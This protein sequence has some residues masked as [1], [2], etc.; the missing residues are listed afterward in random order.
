MLKGKIEFEGK[1]Y[2]DVEMAID[3]AKKE[4]LRTLKIGGSGITSGFDRNVD[5]NYSFEIGNKKLMEQKNKMD[6]LT[7]LVDK[8]MMLE[9]EIRRE[10]EIFKTA[11]N[12]LVTAFEKDTG[13]Y[14]KPVNPELCLTFG[15]VEIDF[16]K[17]K[18]RKEYKQ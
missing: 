11:I 12:E 18:E 7:E 13:V 10:A 14:L 3:E 1:T 5:N 6:D 2:S 16:E 9:E 17:T 4:I 8:K 15:Y